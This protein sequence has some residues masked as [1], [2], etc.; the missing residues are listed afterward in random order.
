MT[1]VF[2]PVCVF[3]CVQA[4]YEPPA[5]SLSWVWSCSSWGGCASPPASSTSHAT[6][7]S[8]ALASS[9]SPQ[10]R[11]EGEREE[12][13]EGWGKREDLGGKRS[14]KL[15]WVKWKKMMLDERRNKRFG[16][17]ERGKGK[18]RGRVE[19]Y[20]M[21][22][23]RNDGNYKWRHLEKINFLLDS[24][25]LCLSTVNQTNGWKL[26]Q[27][28]TEDNTKMLLLNL[29]SLIFGGI[30][31]QYNNVQQLWHFDFQTVASCRHWA[32]LS[33]SRHV[34]GHVMSLNQKFTVYFSPT[35]F[36]R[37]SDGVRQSY[38]ERRRSRD[39]V[40]HVMLHKTLN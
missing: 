18:D 32:V 20:W 15:D 30:W 10:V 17:M 24:T 1:V 13:K 2:L 28:W 31:G 8:S 35:D 9:S 40:V 5:S 12:G 6:T 23:R 21:Y 26:I 37:P 16:Q 27:N 34:F 36:G 38:I 7:S 11:R 29:L 25:Y 3:V 14:R 22:F 39:P 19:V 4:L 33:L